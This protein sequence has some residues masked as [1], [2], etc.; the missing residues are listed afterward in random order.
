AV[1]VDEG[2][3]SYRPANHRRG[4][5]RPRRSDVLLSPNDPLR[6]RNSYGPVWSIREGNRR[7]DQGGSWTTRRSQ[8]AAPAAASDRRAEHLWRMGAGAGRHGRSTWRRRWV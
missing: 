4:V 7:R 3:V 8:Y 1:G 2:F 5:A 6:E